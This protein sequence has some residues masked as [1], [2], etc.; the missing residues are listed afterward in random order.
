MFWSSNV[1]IEKD[2][3]IDYPH[4]SGNQYS[5]SQHISRSEAKPGDLVFWGRNGGIH[6]GAYAGHNQYYSAYGPNGT[7]GIGMM[8]LSSVVGYGKPLFARVRGLKQMMISMKKLKQIL[9]FRNLLKPKLEKAFGKQLAKLLISLGM[10][11]VP[12]M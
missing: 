1:H 9:N 6:V 11:V 10:L 2:F 7:H 12:V 8:P 3:G 4:F 5:V